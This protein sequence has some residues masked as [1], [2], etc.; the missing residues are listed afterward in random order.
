MTDVVRVSAL[1]IEDVKQCKACSNLGTQHAA[2]VGYAKARVMCVCDHPATTDEIES[3]TIFSS[4]WGDYI[5][6]I[7]DQAEMDR[8]EW[9][10]TS[11]AKCRPEPGSGGVTDENVQTCMDKWL[12]QEIALVQPEVIVCCGKRVWH[13]L[14]PDAQEMMDDPEKSSYQPGAYL[15]KDGRA[16][17]ACWHPK[18]YH[19]AN[20]ISSF[21]QVG[22]IIRQFLGS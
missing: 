11:L 19:A 14:V 16:Y 21:V 2:A 22:D 10:F 3:G 5:T 20:D 13:T 18:V 17:V 1:D 12:L 8:E 6:F 7:C 9:Y 4:R 15:R